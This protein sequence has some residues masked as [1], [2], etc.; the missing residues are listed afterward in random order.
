MFKMLALILVFLFYCVSHHGQC[1]PQTLVEFAARLAKD[2]LVQ[3]STELTQQPDVSA[4]SSAAAAP[5][6]KTLKAPIS[7]SILM[8]FDQ[9]GT[10]SV[11]IYIL[12][13]S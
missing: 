2:S 10:S 9:Y 4:A 11:H 1:E 8:N 6:A 5:S 3:K 13:V 7:L 12:H